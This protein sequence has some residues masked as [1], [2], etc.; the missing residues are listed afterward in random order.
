MK[1]G[2]LILIFLLIPS[3]HALGISPAIVE[4]DFKSDEI[5]E[6]TYKVSSDYAEQRIV[7]FVLGDLAEYVKL[8]RDELFG[9]GIFTARI[10]FPSS[11]DKPGPHTI[12]I[13]VEEAPRDEGAIG[14]IVRVIGIV[15]VYV[16]Y[17]GRYAEGSLKIEDGN[18]DEIIPLEVS[19][20]NRGK[21]DLNVDVN[22]L[23]LDGLGE[24]KGSLDFEPFFLISGQE[25]IFRGEFDTM[26]FK[27]GNYMAEA[28]INYGEE[29]MIN[30]SFRIGSL[31]V[32]ITNFTTELPK[33]GIQRFAVNIES[34]WNDNLEEVYA[35]VNISNDFE[36]IVFRTPSEDLSA[37][38]KK[39]L[40][41]FIDTTQLTGD[42]KTEVVL[43]YLGEQ[44]SVYGTLKI[45]E[46]NL[47]YAII[48]GVIVILVIIIGIWLY[49]KRFKSGK[50]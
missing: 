25:K 8:D 6:I 35:D 16:P 37:W 38:G 4:L 41:G 32:N 45:K 19:V 49:R 17:P 31:F 18:V 39:N 48:A 28:Y 42:Y 21:E 10:N 46:F 40:I 1:R 2:I 14:T 33:G 24:R 11:I 23:F 27:A 44:N 26:G 43:S 7:P 13:G 36:S 22:V 12:S 9:S 34:L 47:T 50:R 20:I 15:K 29:L 30:K 3:V 5:I